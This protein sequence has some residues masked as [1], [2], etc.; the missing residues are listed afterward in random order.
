MGPPSSAPFGFLVSLL[1]SGTDCFYFFKFSPVIISE[2]RPLASFV[3]KT[4]T[5]LKAQKLSGEGDL[6]GFR[7]LP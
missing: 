4:E 3:L 7:V 6:S 2:R 1:G 5:D